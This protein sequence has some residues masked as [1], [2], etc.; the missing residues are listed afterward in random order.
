[1]Q[2]NLPHKFSS[3]EEAKRNILK[4]LDDARAKAGKD[5]EIQ[6]ERWEGNTLHFAVVAQGQSLTGKFEVKEKEFS[7]DVKL[8]FYLRMF[9]GR[10]KQAIL[11][12]SQQMLRG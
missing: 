8:P 7:L 12:Q 10:L 9:E 11:E 5:V 3:A 2:L 4:M 1:M 6:E